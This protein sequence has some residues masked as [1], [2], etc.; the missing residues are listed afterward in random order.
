MNARLPTSAAPTHNEE[1]KDAI[2][3]DLYAALPDAPASH[4]DVEKEKNRIAKAG[5]LIVLAGVVGFC[6]WASLAPLDQGVPVHGQ[7]IVSGSRKAVQHQTGG[8]IKEILVK[9]GA[10]VKQGEVLVRMEPTQAGAQAE[11]ARN[12]LYTALAVEARLLAEL[13]NAPKVTYSNELLS[14]KADSRVRPSMELQDQLFAAR[15]A[16]LQA[17]LSGLQENIAGNQAQLS[18]LKE[19]IEA[20]KQQAVFLKEELTG[21]RELAKDGYLPRNRVLERENA[22]LQ[23]TGSLA[24]D[25]GSIGRLGRLINETKLR[26]TQRRQEFQKEVRT[27]LTETQR[28]ARTSRDRLVAMQYELNNT[29]VKAP[30]DGVVVGMHVHTAGG[31]VPSGYVMMDIVPKGQPL[32]VEGQLPIN[33]IDKVA[34]GQDVEMRFSAFNTNTTP[35]IFGKLTLVSA[36][37]L[38]DEQSKQP[39][40][41]INAEAD[42]AQMASM[43][44][45]QVKPGMPVEVFVKTGER[46]F[47]SYL[48]KPLLDRSRNA[49]REE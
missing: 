8:T 2:H 17:E 27:Q 13:T 45:L 47:F 7:V 36:D 38:T 5:W 49:M 12:N 41:K 43:T 31:V 42:A 37:T 6:L 39:Y 10:S 1:M 14:V 29:E 22:Y 34:L 48:F 44:H 24:E 30:A 40:Y 11:I 21:I 16:A 19:A 28:D 46:T 3:S 15:R 4:E 26:Q 9:E 18:G 23:V 25:I 20:K 35:T 33:L 32:I